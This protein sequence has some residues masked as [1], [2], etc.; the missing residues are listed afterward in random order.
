[1]Q[2]RTKIL[3]IIR[4]GKFIPDNHEEYE[5]NLKVLEGRR[6]VKKIQEHKPF[7]P[8]SH[9][10]LGYI[11]KVIFPIIADELGYTKEE[12]KPILKYE[13]SKQTGDELLSFSQS[14]V[15][16]RKVSRFINWV[17]NWSSSEH[18]CYIPAPSEFDW[19]EPENPALLK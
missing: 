11:H 3:G 8:V 2:F 6:V 15:D 17:R 12:M 19:N 4:D 1:M 5:K 18:G 13:Y 7:T 10:Q 9:K 14:E 16:T